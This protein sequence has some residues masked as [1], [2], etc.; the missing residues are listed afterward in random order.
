[1]ILISIL[2]KVST[3]LTPLLLYCSSHQNVHMSAIILAAGHRIVFRAPYYP[4]DGPIEYVFNT[5][6][7]LLRIRNDQITDGNSLVQE[8]NVAIGA[9]PTFEPYFINC[10][11]TLN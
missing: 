6:Q 5:I 9:I 7:G 1:M 10:G 11:F 8:K 2:L 4:V 3:L